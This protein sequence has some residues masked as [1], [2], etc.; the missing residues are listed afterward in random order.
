VPA[1]IDFYF[2]FIS[3]YSYL[4]NTALPRFATRHAASISYRPFGLV[5]L[6]KIVGNRPTS[7]ECRNKGAYV[8]ADLRRW[9]KRYQANLVANSAWPNIDFSELGRGALVAADEGRSADYVN[10]IYRATWG[11]AVDLSQRSELA[12]VL[13][14]AGFDGGQLLERAG[15]P[16]YVAKFERNTAAAAERGVFG[17]PTMFVG[18]EMFFGNDRFDFMAEA[19]RSAA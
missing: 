19:I 6:M 7:V 8:M 5:E 1:E 17:S 12:G 3:P 2:D 15:S 13:A 9:A 4:A 14:K 11:D 18:G 10:A 16:E